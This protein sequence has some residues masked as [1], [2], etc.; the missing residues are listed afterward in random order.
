MNRKW[1]DFTYKSIKDKRIDYG[2]A[3]IHYIL[4]TIKDILSDL[5]VELS[6]IELQDLCYNVYETVKVTDF[7]NRIY[8][9]V[10]K[11]LNKSK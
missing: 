7:D 4:C 10:K 6:D 3:I 1:F 2:E 8:E 5:A 9:L 11:S